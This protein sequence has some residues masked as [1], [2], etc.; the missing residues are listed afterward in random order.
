[1]AA[2]DKNPPAEP[3]PRSRLLIGYIALALLLLMIWQWAWGS[4][5]VTTLPYSEFKE[6]LRNGEIEQCKVEESEIQ[7]VVQPRA[8]EGAEERER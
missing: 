7:G 1:M 6:H 5:T 8:E 4:L 2:P 3:K